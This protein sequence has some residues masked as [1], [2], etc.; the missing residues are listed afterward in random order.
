MSNTKPDI[1]HSFLPE[2]FVAHTNASLTP[3]EGIEIALNLSRE[4]L[5]RSDSPRLERV[6]VAVPREQVEEAARLGTTPGD[7]ADEEYFT[8]LAPEVRLR[9]ALAA[10]SNAPSIRQTVRSVR[11]IT[12][13][14]AF[15][16][17]D[18]NE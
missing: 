11:W 2:G 16:S 3:A 6:A 15:S 12:Q 1:S 5:E 4:A 13:A 14:E 10:R 18:S 9:R 8:R 17:D 7:L